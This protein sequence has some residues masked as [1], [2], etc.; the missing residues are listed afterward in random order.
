MFQ[1]AEEFLHL[2]VDTEQVDVVSECSSGEG[3]RGS[4]EML[5]PL[6]S[7]CAVSEARVSGDASK[8]LF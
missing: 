6:F 4:F 1:L 2:I 8:I 7:G 3:L 5:E